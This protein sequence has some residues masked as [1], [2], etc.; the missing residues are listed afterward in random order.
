VTNAEPLQRSA[1]S[2]DPGAEAGVDKLAKNSLSVAIWTAVSRITGFGRVAV[3]GAV[4]GPTYLSNIY[5][6]TNS[7]PNIVFGL[8]TG[9]LFVTLLVPPLVR[10]IDADDRVASERLACAFLGTVVVVFAT[11]AVLLIALG[12]LVLKLVSLGVQDPG[13]AA[14]Q[15]RTGWILLMMLMPQL[16]LYAVAGTGEAVMNAHGRFALAAAAPALENVGIMATMG[17]TAILYGT[18]ASLG[19]TSGNLLLVLGLG[20]TAAV[21]LHAGAQWWGARRVGVRLVP[22]FAWREPDIRAII[23]R[24]IPSLGFTGLY[25][26]QRF[27]ALVVANRVPGGVV[28]FELATNFYSLPLAVGARPVAVSLLPRLS[29][30]AHGNRLRTFRDELVRG[31]ALVVFLI[32]PAAV[33]YAALA[34]PLAR[35]VSFG[36]MANPTGAALI[37][38]SLLTLAPGVIGS[39]VLLLGTHASYAWQDAKSPFLAML[40]RVILTLGGFVL[41]FL[42]TN[43]IAVLVVL[44]LAVSLADLAG[45]LYLAN[46]IHVRLPAGQARLG[47]AVL[48]ALAGSA[49]MVAP[50]YLVAT[51][52]P[53]LLGGKWSEMIGLL[54]AVFV[55]LVLYITAQALMRSPE[56]GILLGG[57][58]EL[59]GRRRGDHP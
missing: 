4:L 50:A 31:T 16:I 48:R 27:G 15:R 41:A 35:A 43:G 20:T 56:L 55:G 45:S 13:T 33:A 28:A 3:I 57:L 38:V 32:V 10:H 18:G 6:A 25:A 51:C 46:R 42:L 1:A 47:P 19:N 30:L 59:R 44:G 24:A 7:L 17:A 29:R 23:G 9:S 11:V 40:V 12:P 21:G 39:A 54:A 2:Q 34:Y 53:A 22:R 58:R 49:V 37:A 14:T 26:V 52:V 5:Q 36:E 8:L